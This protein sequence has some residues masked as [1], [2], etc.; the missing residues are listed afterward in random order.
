MNHATDEKKVHG[1]RLRFHTQFRNCERS[2]EAPAKWGYKRKNRRLRRR[3]DR[4]RIVTEL[5]EAAS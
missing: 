1:M 2:R 4:F 3:M 5:R